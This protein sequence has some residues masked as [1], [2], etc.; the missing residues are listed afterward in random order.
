MNG[1]GVSSVVSLVQRPADR[2]P[3]LEIRLRIRLATADEAGQ[4]AQIRRL[5][6]C[7]NKA[8]GKVTG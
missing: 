2:T 8:V 1:A 7:L 6:L 5:L 3:L 4:V